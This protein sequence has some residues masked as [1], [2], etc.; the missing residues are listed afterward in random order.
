MAP[1]CAL[2]VKIGLGCCSKE[3]GV[4][5]ALAQLLDQHHQ[6]LPGRVVGVVLQ[7]GQSKFMVGNVKMS[8][9][10]VRYA[11][12]ESDGGTLEGGSRTVLLLQWPTAAAEFDMSSRDPTEQAHLHAAVH[13]PSHSVSQQP[14]CGAPKQNRAP[15][16]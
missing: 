8:N 12:R 15:L 16:M 4:V 14:L 9:L 2:P 11:N 6:L 10:S 13:M 5:A 3:V 1:T 7:P